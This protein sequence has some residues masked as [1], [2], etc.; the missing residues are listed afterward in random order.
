MPKSLFLAAY[1]SFSNFWEKQ[2]NTNEKIK[3]T[4]DV[5]LE[6]IAGLEKINLD[7]SPP[8]PNKHTK[9]AQYALLNTPS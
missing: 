2:N 5:G 6:C 8:Y 3:K 4:S 1:L 7:F 9:V